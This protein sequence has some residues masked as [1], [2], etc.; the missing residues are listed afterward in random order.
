[1]AAALQAAQPVIIILLSLTRKNK[2][3]REPADARRQ[4]RCWNQAGNGYQVN[5]MCMYKGDP[6]PWTRPIALVKRI[7]E[8]QTSRWN[9]N[10]N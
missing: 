8:F 10:L 9:T 2:T 6:S 4:L 3:N 5:W 1:V 7:S